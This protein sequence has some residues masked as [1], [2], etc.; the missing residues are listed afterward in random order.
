MSV[1]VDTNILLRSIE[2][3]NASHELAVRAT[4]ALISF[5]TPQI[6]AEFW[7]VATHP[8]ERNGLGL[9]PGEARKEL[10]QLEGFFALV[11]ESSDVYKEWKGLVMVHGVSGVQA[12]DARLVAAMKVYGVTKILTFDAQ[13][14]V[15]YQDIEVVNPQTVGAA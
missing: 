13:D 8:R 3:S 10:D 9:T 14:F 4:A 15:R 11:G 5:I 6:M 7:N 2:S 12:H 1:F